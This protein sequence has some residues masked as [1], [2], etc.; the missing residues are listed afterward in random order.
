MR[1]CFEGVV[2]TSKEKKNVEKLYFST[3]NIIYIFFHGKTDMLYGAA[4][5]LGALT[6][7]LSRYLP[8]LPA[9]PGPNSA[10]GEEACRRRAVNPGVPVL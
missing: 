9:P 8:P 3:S 5:V 4:E 2:N 7:Q 1:A 6:S 10:T